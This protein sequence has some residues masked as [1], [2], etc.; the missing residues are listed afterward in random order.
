MPTPDDFGAHGEPA[1]DPELL[2]WL[3]VELVEH[4][5]SLKHLHRLMVLSNAYRQ[6]SRPA[7][8]ASKR[9]DPDNRLLWRMN[10]RRLDA[11]GLRERRPGRG[12]RAQ[13]RRRRAD[14]AHTA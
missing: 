12:R 10:R 2:D 9:I 11:E 14:G 7:D 6:D 5:W 1:A 13:P 8:A 4:G 3:A